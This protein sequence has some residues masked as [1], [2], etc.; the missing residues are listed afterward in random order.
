MISCMIGHLEQ[1]C[2]ERG[3]TLD[4]AR[5]CIVSQDGDT[6]TVDETHPAF[7]RPR[8]GLGD[9]VASALDAIGITKARVESLVGGPCSCPE[10]QAALNS[11]GEKWLGMPPGSTANPGVDAR[12]GM[13][14][15]DE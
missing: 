12:T 13:G 7:P 2:R 8:P 9:R 5:P 3:Y 11:I 14:K 4:E 1:R 15:L 10:R 6:I